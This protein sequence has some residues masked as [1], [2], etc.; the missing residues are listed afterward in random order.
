MTRHYVNLTNGIEAIPNLN[1]TDYG[2]I[3]IQSTACEQHLWDRLLQD[4]DY[5]F[6]MHVAL[7][8]TC[9]IHD[10]GTNKPRSR[11]MYQG[12][13]FIKYVLYKRW[14]NMEYQSDVS[15]YDT[16]HD[17]ANKYF[18]TCYHNLDKRTK[19]KLDY[20]KPY[21]MT[22]DIHIETVCAATCHDNDRAY[23]RGILMNERSRTA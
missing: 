18:A 13:E 15:K 1:A 8:D 2:F 12:V 3:R 9:I 4:L 14:L 23:Y 20:F 11:A 17:N 5:D 22:S 7:G 19:T 21:I 16:H 6:L 10:Y